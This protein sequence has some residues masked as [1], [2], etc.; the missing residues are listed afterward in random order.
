LAATAQ[1]EKN[2]QLVEKSDS[3]QRHH[4]SKNGDGN[5]SSTSAPKLLDLNW[6]P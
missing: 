3:E 5:H 1:K 4:T 2:A 6:K